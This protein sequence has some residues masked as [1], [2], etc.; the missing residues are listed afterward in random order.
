[1]IKERYAA[2]TNYVKIFLGFVNNE[3]RPEIVSR[4][5]VLLYYHHHLPFKIL[6]HLFCNLSA[7]KRKFKKLI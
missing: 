2:R 5:H 7:E 6:T 3:A 1:M 4:H